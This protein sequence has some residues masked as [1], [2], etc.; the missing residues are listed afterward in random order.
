[1]TDESLVYDVLE[2]VFSLVA[3]TNALLADTSGD[4]RLTSVL[5]NAL[6]QIEPPGTLTMRQLADAL[7]VDPSTVT[8]IAGR[9]EDKGLIAREPDPADRRIKIVSLTEQGRALREQLGEA[10]FTQSYL[11]RLSTTEQR[12]LKRL[13]AKA[14]PTEPAPGQC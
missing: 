8:F 13:L 7:H 14:I 9:L 12:Q 2:L 11:V 3:Q 10:M 1:M 6:W 5:A 4:L